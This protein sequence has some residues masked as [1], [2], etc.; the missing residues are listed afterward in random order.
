MKTTYPE[1]DGCMTVHLNNTLYVDLIC[2]FAEF[3]RLLGGK[4]Y[5]L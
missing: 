5:D 4:F 1:M 3:L 2:A